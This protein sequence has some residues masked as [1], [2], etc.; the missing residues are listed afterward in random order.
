MLIVISGPSGVG[1]GTVVEEVIKFSKN[2]KKSISCT[3]RPPRHNEIKGYHYH[4][5][6]IEEFKEKIKNQ[7]FL[8]WAEVHNYN[9]GTPL[10]PIEEYLK[11]GYDVVLEVDIQGAASIRTALA[12]K[13]EFP[14]KCFLIFLIPPSFE[15]LSERLKKRQ[16]E[17]QEITDRRLLRAAIEF[18]AMR[19]FD[20]LVLNKDFK[21]AVAEILTIINNERSLQ[22]G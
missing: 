11:K 7:E 10:S 19:H 20:Y 1:K 2:L 6:T 9:Y 17:T 21:K 5:V 16:T 12:K 13:K 22:N 18:Q 4:F 14:A 8:E 3:T 15:A